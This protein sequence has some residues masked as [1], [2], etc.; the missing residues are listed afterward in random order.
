MVFCA[1]LKKEPTEEKSPLLV[2]SLLLG[3]ALVL[4][5]LPCCLSLLLPLHIL[6]QGLLV[7]SILFLSEGAIEVLRGSACCWLTGEL[8]GSHSAFKTCQFD[9]THDPTFRACHE[10]FAKRV[11]HR[12]S[13][14]ETPGPRL[15]NKD[16]RSRQPQEEIAAL[17]RMMNELHC[18]AHI[19]LMR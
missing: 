9:T 14:M 7:C 1:F 3:S 8:D 5:C 17:E 11:T 12:N 16:E 18:A 6:Q 13:G 2:S 4:L 19:R 15:S 10:A